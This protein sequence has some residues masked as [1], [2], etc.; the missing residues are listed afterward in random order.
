MNESRYISNNTDI[1]SQLVF[2]LTRIVHES[3][4]HQPWTD[5]FKNKP[6][7]LWTGPTSLAYLF[8]LGDWTQRE[9]FMAHATAE[10]TAEG[11][12]DGTFIAGYDPYG[13]LWGEGGRAWGG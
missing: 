5:P 11:K 8:S 2:L 6:M 9:H 12:K 13:L 4:P 1:R 3:R 7:G 10:K